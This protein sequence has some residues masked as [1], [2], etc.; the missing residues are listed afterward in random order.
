M[1]KAIGKSDEAVRNHLLFGLLLRYPKCC[2][3]KFAEGAD[4]RTKHIVV[5]CGFWP[6]E[7]HNKLSQEEAEDLIGRELSEAEP[8]AYSALIKRCRWVK[9]ADRDKACRS[10]HKIYQD[11]GQGEFFEACWN[12]AMAYPYSTVNLLPKRKKSGKGR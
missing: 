5:H 4:Y 1:V 11:Y 7:I 12:E 2:V 3:L 9:L 10:F 8:E 6:C